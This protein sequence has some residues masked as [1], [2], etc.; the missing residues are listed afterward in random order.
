MIQEIVEQG[1]EKP[2]EIGPN[3]MCCWWVWLTIFVG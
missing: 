1:Y 2:E 3:G